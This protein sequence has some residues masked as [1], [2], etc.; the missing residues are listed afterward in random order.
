MT[1]QTNDDLQLEVDLLKNPTDKPPPLPE[2]RAAMQ[3]VDKH[4]L[5]AAWDSN[6][7]TMKGVLVQLEISRRTNVLTRVLALGATL[8]NVIMLYVVIDHVRVGVEDVR[9]IKTAVVESS[10]VST[11]RAQKVQQTLDLVADAMVRLMEARLAEDAAR[12]KPKDDKLQAVAVQA[13]HTALVTAL[14]AKKEIVPVAERPAVELQLQQL[15]HP[16]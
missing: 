8:V 4:R 1:K 14:E 6:V 16:P 3:L 9:V 10:E 2:A 15:A 11:A 5:L 12:A 13:K 7:R